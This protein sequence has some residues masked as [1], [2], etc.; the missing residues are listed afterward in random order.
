MAFTQEQAMAPGKIGYIRVVLTDYGV[1]GTPETADYEVQILQ[2]DG[3]YF[4]RAEGNLVPHLSAAQG[5]G[6]LALMA[7]LRTKAQALLPK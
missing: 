7:N 4:R 2:K 1:E 6:L 5:S 3:S